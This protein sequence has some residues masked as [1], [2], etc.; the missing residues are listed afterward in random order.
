MPLRLAMLVATHPD[1]PCEEALCWNAKVRE[2]E[3]SVTILPDGPGLADEMEKAINSVRATA[4]VLVY[5]A[6]TPLPATNVQE[7]R[8]PYNRSDDPDSISQQIAQALRSRDEEDF[9]RLA[10]SVLT[11]LCASEERRYEALRRFLGA[12][13]RA[14]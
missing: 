6:G 14:R 11:A 12:Q 3:L 1:A 8:V 7:S 9:R 5:H 13:M 10:H 4:C 2:D